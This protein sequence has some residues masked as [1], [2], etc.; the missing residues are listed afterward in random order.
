MATYSFLVLA[1]CGMDDTH[2]EEDFRCIRNVLEVF[3]CIVEF[4]VV[5][6]PQGGD[7]GFYFLAGVSRGW[8]ILA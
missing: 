4:V 6:P 7:P 1:K 3:Q 8:Q 2:I 5:I